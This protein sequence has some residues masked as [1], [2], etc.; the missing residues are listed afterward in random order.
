MRNYKQ[1]VNISMNKQEQFSD[2]ASQIS[3]IDVHQ[4]CRPACRRC[5]LADP[6]ERKDCTKLGHL[7]LHVTDGQASC[8]L[9]LLVSSCLSLCGLIP[10]QAPLLGHL[11]QPRCVQ[12]APADLYMCSSQATLWLHECALGCLAASIVMVRWYALACPVASNCQS[13]S[14]E[15]C[16]PDGM[17]VL[18]PVH[19]KHS[20]N[21]SRT[22]PAHAAARGSSL[23]A[24]AQLCGEPSR[25]H[26]PRDPSLLSGSSWMLAAWHDGTFPPQAVRSTQPADAD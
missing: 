3:Q 1:L 11:P 20:L 18:C 10:H 21:A 14:T 22:L 24:G 4:F 15:V 23:H 13:L 26:L 19:D 5:T 6:I 12:P 25:K 16:H 8:S 9:P 7:C 2:N 17:A